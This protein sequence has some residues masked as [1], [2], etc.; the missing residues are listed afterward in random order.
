MWIMLEEMDLNAS[1]S[2]I[3]KLNIPTGIPLVY[4][5]NDNLRPAK[6]YYL[7]TDEELREALNEVANQGKK[8]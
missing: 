1:D 6:H 8:K 2:D 5:L 4:E 7:A 3:L